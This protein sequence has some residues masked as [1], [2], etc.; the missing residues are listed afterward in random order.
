MG[1]ADAR[2]YLHA[3]VY[4]CAHTLH[5]T[6]LHSP[7]RM[8]LY[9]VHITASTHMHN[10]PARVHTHTEQAARAGLRRGLPRSPQLFSP[11][12]LLLTA[13]WSCFQQEGVGLQTSVG[14][15]LG[16]GTGRRGPSPGGRAG[17]GQWRGGGASRWV[18]LKGLSPPCSVRPGVGAARY[19]KYRAPLFSLSL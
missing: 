5:V 19:S 4:T 6:D 8:C 11:E 1:N 14:G 7:A 10:T 17:R 16:L 2:T 18:R 3:T 12:P 15:C 13:R 9:N